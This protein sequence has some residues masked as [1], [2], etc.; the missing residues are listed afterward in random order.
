MTAQPPLFGRTDIRD[1]AR[2]KAR[3]LDTKG[4]P[5]K[6]TPAKGYADKPGSGPEGETC[7]SCQHAERVE[8]HRK[9]Y[10]KC[11]MARN[12]WT[13]GT[14]SDIRLKSPACSLWEAKGES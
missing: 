1:A 9:T 10:R 11:G 4:R 6:P 12:K 5:R 3:W 13:H 2:D 7:G 8:Y 14:G